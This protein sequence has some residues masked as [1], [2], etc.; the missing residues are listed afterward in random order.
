MIFAW[1]YMTALVSSA[2]TPHVAAWRNLEAGTPHT[3]WGLVWFWLPVAQRG[4]LEVWLLCSS[5][6]DLE[7]PWCI[8]CMFW[9]RSNVNFRLQMLGASAI[10]L[11]QSMHAV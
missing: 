6:G 3:I 1:L 9:I 5:D 2:A 10:G 4:T 11:S 7:A 8:G